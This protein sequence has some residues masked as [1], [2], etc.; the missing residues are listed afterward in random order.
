MRYGAG[1]VL[2]GLDLDVR[3]GE[4]LAVLG[5]NGAGKTTMMEILEGYRRR[6]SGLVRVL[7]RD[8]ERAGRD[9]RERIGI[10]LQSS[11]DHGS[12]TVRSL[13]EH[14]EAHFGRTWPIDELLA[15]TSIPRRGATCGGC[16][17]TCATLARRSS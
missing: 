16:S 5:P 11:G 4:V 12:W 14:V 8:P 15:R 13:L 17:R 1:P 10:V 3:R 2:R 7:G 9:W 6:S